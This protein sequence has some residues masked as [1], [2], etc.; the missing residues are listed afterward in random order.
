VQRGQLALKV[1]IAYGTA[2]DQ[3]IALRLQALAAVKGLSV[4]VPPA[5]TRGVGS[6][7]LDPQSEAHLRE[8]DVVLGVITGFVSEFCRQELNTA[9]NLGKK[10]ILLAEPSLASWLEPY[11]PGNLVIT[12]PADPVGAEQAIVQFLKKADIEQNTLKVLL[13][14]GTLAL[15]LLLFPSED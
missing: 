5:H 9:K 6:T 12:D 14:L 10:T 3:I 13:G 11:F 15:A 2:S 1:Y 4:Y 7:V 8:S